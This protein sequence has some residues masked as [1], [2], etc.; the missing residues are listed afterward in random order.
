MLGKH[1]C[2]LY[3]NEAVDFDDDTTI[4]TPYKLNPDTF[5]HRN[6]NRKTGLFEG[7]Y[8]HGLGPG[9]LAGPVRLSALLQ[10]HPPLVKSPVIQ[11]FD[12]NSLY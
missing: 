4:Q 2:Y 3:T 12:F 5:G 8:D 10:S 9:C 1:I 6:R 11:S 7:V